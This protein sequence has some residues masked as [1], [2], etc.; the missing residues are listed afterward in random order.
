MSALAAR[1]E[2]TRR[3]NRF[4]TRQLGLLQAGLLDTPYTLTEAR[5][6]FELGRR[7][8]LEVKTLRAEL[9]L[10]PAFLSRRLASL[11]A[12]KLVELQ[13]STGD[14]RQ[15]T[16]RLTSKG[17]RAFE[18]LDRRSAAQ[19][20]ALLSRLP[21]SAQRSLVQA[22]S[23]VRAC[24]GDTAPAPVVGIRGL[25]PGDLGW[26]VERHGALYAQ[27]YAWDQTFEG[28]VARIVSDYANQ[29]D[30]RGQSAWIA[31]LDGERAGCVFCVRKSARVGQLRMLLVEPAARGHG[32]GRK[33]VDECLRFARQS[34]YRQLVLWTNDVLV[35]ARRI[36]QA[37]GFT[38]VREGKHHS[39][40]HDLVEQSWSLDL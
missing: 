15:K 21:D 34:G 39:F 19:I 31:E 32:L 14:A 22:M 9:E 11:R 18:Q 6:L 10:D 17:E 12:L 40:G 37:A 35:A 27:E 5:L 23:T 7:G 24:L 3:F 8:P 1:V 29:K 25:R 4:W 20:A 36:Y 38:L 13:A 28:L 2:A 30:P 16:T 33:L 26:V